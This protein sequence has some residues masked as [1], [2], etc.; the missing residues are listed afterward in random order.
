M[1]RYV[2]KFEWQENLQDFIS[3][4]VFSA[5]IAASLLCNSILLALQVHTRTC[6]FLPSFLLHLSNMYEY[7]GFEN[8]SIMTPRQLIFLRKSDCLWCAVLLC[9]VVCL[10]LHAYFFLPSHLSLKHVYCSTTVQV[11]IVSGLCIMC[12]YDVACAAPH[13]VCIRH[14]L[15]GSAL[16]VHTTLPVR[17]CIICAYDVA[18]AGL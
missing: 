18:C 4:P 10:T 13:Y 14:C 2:P 3:H 8:M 6:F 12:A 16:C 9:L 7:R 5:I 17:L 1:F 11:T 15:C